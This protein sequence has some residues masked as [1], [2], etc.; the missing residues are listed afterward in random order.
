VG[1]GKGGCVMK[2]ADKIAHAVFIEGAIALLRR[3]LTDRLGARVEVDP[4]GDGTIASLFDV[5]GNELLTHRLWGAQLTL[6][7]AA[8][9]VDATLFEAPAAPP[10]AADPLAPGHRVMRVGDLVV[11]RRAKGAKR[12]WI[13]REITDKG[14]ILQRDDRPDLF[15]TVT[16]AHI[17]LD[18][19]DLWR[20]SS[21]HDGPS[22]EPSRGDVRPV[23]APA[24]AALASDITG[25]SVGDVINLDG[26]KVEVV[27]VD[28][29]GFVW[30]AVGDE[31][32]R[33]E[34]ALDWDD[35]QHITAD[36]W[37][38]RTEAVQ[39][40]RS[41]KKK[42]TKK[43]ASTASAKPSRAEVVTTTVDVA[44]LRDGRDFSAVPEHVRDLA[45]LAEPGWWCVVAQDATRSNET[46][47][48]L[49][50]DLD[51]ACSRRDRLTEDD[52]GANSLDRIVLFN[53]EGAFL[54]SE[55]WFRHSPTSEA[56]AQHPE[57]RLFRVSTPTPDM[58]ENAQQWAMANG[59]CWYSA[60][61][62]RISPAEIAQG[63]IWLLWMRQNSD[64]VA[65]VPREA[66]LFVER[67]ASGVLASGRQRAI[68]TIE[69]WNATDDHSALR[70]GSVVSVGDVDWRVFFLSTTT[71]TLTRGEGDTEEVADC[72][73]DDIAP[74]GVGGRW[75]LAGKLRKPKSEKAPKAKAPKLHRQ[76][77]EPDA[78]GLAI[79]G[80][81]TVLGY[82]E[83]QWT[84]LA[85]RE[86]DVTAPA[87]KLHA[88]ECSDKGVRVRLYDSAPR[89][90]WDSLDGGEP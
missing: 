52:R 5:E 13:V 12:D 11:E 61:H 40:T 10:P 20:L 35:V 60:T 55:S 80:Q 63:D 24:S 16:W 6:P 22:A 17:D 39:P 86:A 46:Q 81:H 75:W 3:A 68:L 31:V 28:S 73:I 70:V 4:T 33:D 48:S 78:D 1:H 56:L 50:P 26:E 38:T 15:E 65:I 44:G 69:P 64:A 41:K 88:K 62:E 85:I 23:D 2:A 72:S 43:A 67:R 36:V 18:A 25:L 51:T 27:T 84:T 9:A 57:A 30:R 53:D 77:K 87:W 14:P 34:G 49:C 83:E 82:L 89:C 19:A 79:R 32:A 76:T 21:E 71:V 74:T 59:L 90:V 47:A 58:R 8:P 45:P 66:L 7:L 29:L 42:R 37:S 54:P